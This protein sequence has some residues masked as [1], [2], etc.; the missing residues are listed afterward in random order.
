MN[1][2][3]AMGIEWTHGIQNG[4]FTVL[5]SCSMY[6]M[7]EHNNGAYVRFLKS[8]VTLKAHWLCCCYRGI[9]EEQLATLCQ[10]VM[11]KKEI[12]TMVTVVSAGSQREEGINVNGMELSIETRTVV[13]EES[14]D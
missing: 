7:L 14:R 11:T 10:P 8:L 3:F 4:L 1:M 13:D 2:L 9:V 5:Y 6:I 12:S